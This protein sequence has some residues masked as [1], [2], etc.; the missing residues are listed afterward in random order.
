[1]RN[2]LK[3]VAP[4]I[5]A[6]LDPDFRPAV[7]ANRAFRAEV[8]ASGQGIPLAIAL[9]R[10]SG[11]ISVYETQ[12]FGPAAGRGAANVAYAERIVKF[13]LWQRG[14]WKITIGGD[15]EVAAAIKKAYAP[16]GARAFDVGLMSDVYEQPFTVEAVELANIPEA[17]DV[18][19]ALGG[20]LDGCRVGFDLGASN[21]KASAVI[22]G[23]VVFS[24]EVG[25]DPSNQT[26]PQYH[27]DE[28]MSAIRT[29]ASHLPRLDAVGGSA[30]G[31]YVNNRTLVGSLYRGI[32]KDLF[33]AHIKDMY[34]NI[35]KEL[36]VPLVLV[37]D[38]EVTALAGGL[39]LEDTGVLGI[40]MGSSE[41][42]G[43]LN[44]DGHITGWLDELAFCP[45]DY[46]PD[47]AVDEWS[48]DSGCGVVYFSLQAV[49]RLAPVAG[50]DVEKDMGQPEIL[51]LVQELQQ[52]DDQRAHAIM[53]TIGVYL[54]YTIAHYAD[55][56]DI[57]HL[58]ILG[59]VTSGQGGP[60]ILEEARRVLAKEFPKLAESIDLHLPEEA[61]RRVGQSIAAASLPE[62][63]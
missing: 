49:A 21:R 2:A 26:D 59:G 47:A 60:I 34:V 58:L 8:D 30:A 36:G 10:E 35:S 55:F 24:E 53:Q 63:P 17:S 46:N 56:Y 54:G 28:V 42:G 12:I 38:G 51:K 57:K 31:I 23:K 19:E 48:G 6:P 18:P 43:Y 25:W 39:D 37:N 5:E 3:L 13:L 15:A 4:G 62:L 29:A 7:L 33:E 11:K 22:D 16:D 27:Y 44:L 61:N 32:P 14:G 20:H 50:I 40:A 41:A 52:E 9:E 1:M 45:M